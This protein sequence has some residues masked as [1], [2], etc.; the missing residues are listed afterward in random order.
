MPMDGE[1]SSC[2]TQDFGLVYLGV[3]SPQIR[4]NLVEGPKEAIYEPNCG[5]HVSWDAVVCRW[6]A[7]ALVP[8]SDTPT[9]GCVKLPR[10]GTSSPGAPQPRVQ[11]APSL[12]EGITDL[13]REAI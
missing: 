5:R 3:K 11:T 1:S 4:C 6:R 8:A 9:T 2:F 10:P 12:E 13:A 7:E